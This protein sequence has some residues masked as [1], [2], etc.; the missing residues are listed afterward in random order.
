M[1]TG[2]VVNMDFAPGMGAIQPDDGSEVM[3]FSHTDVLDPIEFDS[4][5]TFDKGVQGGGTQA[6]NVRPVKSSDR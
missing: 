2:K 3:P 6:V 4:P 1:L 5:V